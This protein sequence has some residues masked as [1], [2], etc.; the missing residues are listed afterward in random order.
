MRFSRAFAIS[1]FAPL[2]LAVPLTTQATLVLEPVF[3]FAPGSGPDDTVF[4][5]YDPTFINPATGEAYLLSDEPGEVSTFPAGFPV[6]QGNVDTF[7]FYNNTSYDITGFTWNIVGYADE[8]ELFNFTIFR[9]PDVDARFGD[10][11][12]DG[13]IGRSDIFSTIQ[14]SED[15]KVIVFKDGL[16]PVNGRFTDFI[17]A[18]TDDGEPFKAAIDSHFEGDFV[19][20]PAAVWLFGS[21]LALLGWLRRK[22][23]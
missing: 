18:M 5:I 22:A 1:I 2:I 3:D 17:F 19:P 10:V 8:P 11:D 20:V 15:G 6:D 12:G 9:D 7:R 14:V 16:I 23:G 4:G 21:A 13:Q